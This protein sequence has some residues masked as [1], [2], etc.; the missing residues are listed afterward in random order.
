MASATPWSRRVDKSSWRTRGSPGGSCLSQRLKLAFAARAMRLRTHWRCVG[1]EHRRSTC[2]GVCVLH[3]SC[4]VHG[5]SRVPR[6]PKYKKCRIPSVHL[7][8]V[9]GSHTSCGAHGAP[10]ASSQ[11]IRD[12]REYRRSTSLGLMPS[13]RRLPCTVHDAPRVPRDHK[14][15][16]CRIPSVHLS[17]VCG[18]HAS[19]T[20]RGAPRASRQW[21]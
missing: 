8:R 2:Y 13:M 18:S 21:V 15:K 9:C 7:S 10:C 14:H 17:R 11:W 20:V 1:D 3:A 12:E 19:C 16:K 4:T 6:D 5:A